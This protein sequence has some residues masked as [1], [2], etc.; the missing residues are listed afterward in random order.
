M[1][2]L[3]PPHIVVDKECPAT[4][5]VGGGYFV[6]VILHQ[7]LHT[8]GTGQ[9]GGENTGKRYEDQAQKSLHHGV[10]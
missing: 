1:A 5:R 4:G 3:F 8:G 7:P 2:S 10:S 9:Q 6:S